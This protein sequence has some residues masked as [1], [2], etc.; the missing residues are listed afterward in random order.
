MKRVCVRHDVLSIFG[1]LSDRSHRSQGGKLITTVGACKL[2]ALRNASAVDF[3]PWALSFK[4]VR[5]GNDLKCVARAMLFTDIHDIHA[6]WLLLLEVNMAFRGRRVNSH[7]LELSTIH[8]AGG[9]SPLSPE[10]VHASRR[11]EK[12]PAE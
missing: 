11:R 5:E 7:A 12:L 1:I 8:E 3:K 4:H 6:C 2:K 9:H 10:K